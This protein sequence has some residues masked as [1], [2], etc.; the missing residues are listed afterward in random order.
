MLKC[1]CFSALPVLDKKMLT[2]LNNNN[3]K[4]VIYITENLNKSQ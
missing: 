2:V 1:L 3:K 4:I